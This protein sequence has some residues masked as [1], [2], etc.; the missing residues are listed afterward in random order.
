MSGTPETHE[1]FGL[2]LEYTDFAVVA[3]MTSNSDWGAGRMT[4]VGLCSSLARSPCRGDTTLAQFSLFWR[5]AHTESS[6]LG[7]IFI[8]PYFILIKSS[9]HLLKEKKTRRKCIQDENIL[10]NRIS[11][12]CT[13]LNRINILCFKIT[14]SH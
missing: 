7:Q 11:M 3:T 13:Y 10:L 9:N 2:I 5:A 12:Y 14:L 4:P 6:E 8:L 1:G